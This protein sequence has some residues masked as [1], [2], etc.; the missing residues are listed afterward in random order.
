MRRAVDG[1]RVIVVASAIVC[2]VFLIGAKAQEDAALAKAL[3]GVTVSLEQGLRASGAQGTPISGK[4]E[5]EEG[6]LQLS[7]Y[8]TKAG[9]FS[10]VVVDYKT[11]KIA[12][13]DAITS[14]ED[15]VAAKAQS[16]AL[17]TAKGTLLDA[18]A[19]ARKANAGARAVS[20]TAALE[21]GHPVAKIVVLQGQ[22]F[23]TVS[24][25]LD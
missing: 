10:E 17:G 14:G 7:V 2:L 8:T 5:V 22:T 11:G 20:A 21:D 25:K 3:T 16:A 15:L 6:K 18:V 9:K 12:K 4:F 1:R 24:E 23:K 13:T 19:R